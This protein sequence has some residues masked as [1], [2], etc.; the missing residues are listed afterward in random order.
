MFIVLAKK[1]QKLF[2]PNNFSNLFYKVISSPFILWKFYLYVL[3]RI[4]L[5]HCDKYLLPSLLSGFDSNEC[6]NVTVCNSENCFGFKKVKIREIVFL[7][8]IKLSRRP[9][10]YSCRTFNPDFII[11]VF[12]TYKRGVDFYN[13]YLSIDCDQEEKEKDE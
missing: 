13:L 2:G 4:V 1:R 10:I 3:A 12:D 9:A 7:H 5:N 6:G 8:A 11:N